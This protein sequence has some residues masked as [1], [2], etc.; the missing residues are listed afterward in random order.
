[1]FY[2]YLASFCC[3]LEIKENKTLPISLWT[4]VAGP[5]SNKA[6]KMQ[7]LIIIIEKFHQN[8]HCVSGSIETFNRRPSILDGLLMYFLFLEDSKRHIPDNTFLCCPWRHKSYL[9]RI[10]KPVFVALSWYYTQLLGNH[11]FFGW[12]NIIIKT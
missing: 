10:T 6:K 9:C 2:R 8:H 11:F 7:C 1:M 12:N 4:K 3:P 5:L